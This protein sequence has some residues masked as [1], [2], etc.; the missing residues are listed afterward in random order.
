[1]KAHTPSAACEMMSGSFCAS[2]YCGSLFC[3]NVA[4]TFLHCVIFF[5]GEEVSGQIELK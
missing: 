3:L 4:S 5:C 2:M 1:M